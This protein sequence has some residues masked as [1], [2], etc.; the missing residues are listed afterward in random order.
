MAGR[1]ALSAPD[2]FPQPLYAFPAVETEIL[3]VMP[4]LT[5]DIEG[6]GG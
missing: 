4:S 2:H 1:S 6:G 3:E 5:G